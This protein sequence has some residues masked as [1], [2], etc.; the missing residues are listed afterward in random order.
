MLNFLDLMKSFEIHMNAND[1]AIGGALMQE[2]HLDHIWN[3]VLKGVVVV[4]VKS[5]KWIVCNY[6]LF[7]SLT[8]LFGGT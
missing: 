7:Y 6:K 8:T 2:G 1:F 5:W 3:Q 4:M